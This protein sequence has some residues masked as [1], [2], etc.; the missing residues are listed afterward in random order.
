MAHPP[1][2]CGAPVS[3]GANAVIKDVSTETFMNDVIEASKSGP[4]VVDFWA[5]W[6]GPCKQLGSGHRKG[7]LR[8][9]W[10]RD[11]RQD[12][13]REISGSRGPDGHPVHSRRRRLRRWSSGR[14]VHGRKARIGSARLHR[15]AGRCRAGSRRAVRR[16]GDAG[17]R[18]HDAGQ[19]RPR[20]CGGSLWHGRAARARQSR[21]TGRSRAV[22]C[23]RR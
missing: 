3:A 11:A 4:V 5:P 23:G 15:Q 7:R 8:S 12:G 13:H 20:R 9:R 14:S 19:R 16:Q 10:A 6:C 18:R 2:R 1:R 17:C 22:L 21:C